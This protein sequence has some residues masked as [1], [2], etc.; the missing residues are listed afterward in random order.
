MCTEGKRKKCQSCFKFDE[1]FTTASI[2]WSLIGFILLWVICMTGYWN[3]I[4]LTNT[5]TKVS[6]QYEMV[7]NSTVVC[8]ANDN[9]ILETKDMENVI[10]ALVNLRRSNINYASKQYSLIPLL[11][12]IIFFSKPYDQQK[13]FTLSAVQV[14]GVDI[15]VLGAT[16]IAP[17]FPV[18]YDESANYILLYNQSYVDYVLLNKFSTNV[19]NASET[20][21]SNCISNIRLYYDFYDVLL[22]GYNDAYFGIVALQASFTLYSIVLKA[23]A[24]RVEK[25]KKE[26]AAKEKSTTL[27]STEMKA[28]V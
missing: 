7:K 5:T 13:F 22:N 25:T 15:T 11:N 21:G 6:S 27:Q 12:I 23:Y 2:F 20:I 24:F 4:N 26:N 19:I 3:I 14:V 17:K 1:H 18:M 28:N 16:F 10:Y 8:S 9:I